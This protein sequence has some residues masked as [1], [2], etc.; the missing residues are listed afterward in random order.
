MGRFWFLGMLLTSLGLRFLA[1]LV[2]T[3]CSYDT[4]GVEC[5]FVLEVS[6]RLG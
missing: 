6:K 3:F 1:F 2:Q 4:I 5:R